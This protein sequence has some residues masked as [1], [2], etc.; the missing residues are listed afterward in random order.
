MKVKIL[1][2]VAGYGYFGGEVADLPEVHVTALLKKAAVIVV[3]ETDFGL[4]VTDG[5]G[6]EATAEA[7]KIENVEDGAVEDAAEAGKTETAMGDVAAEAGAAQEGKEAGG[8][9]LAEE[10]LPEGMPM[11]SVLEEYGFRSVK[12][13]AAAGE[14]LL[15]VPG[16]GKATM[17]RILEFCGEQ[18]KP[19]ADAE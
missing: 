4:T 7:D 16:V 2:P 17:K 19:A 15:D 8:E 6:G 9:G 1:R 10:G 13:V 12:E 3:P 11:R 14:G 5:I 18:E